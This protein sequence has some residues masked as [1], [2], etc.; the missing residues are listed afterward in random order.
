M[1]EAAVTKA[2]IPGIV[3]IVEFFDKQGLVVRKNNKKLN[4]LVQLMCNGHL[5]WMAIGFLDNFYRRVSKI[6][7]MM[8][9]RLQ[10]LFIGSVFSPDDRTQKSALRFIL[11]HSPC[12][13][14]L[15]IITIDSCGVFDFLKDLTPRFPNLETITWCGPLEGGLH[16][17]AFA[18]EDAGF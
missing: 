8:K 15:E 9:S 5:E 2:G 6:P 1:F 7:L 11:E 4:P 17:D 16:A 14:N 12:L 18:G 3:L 13:R 10:G